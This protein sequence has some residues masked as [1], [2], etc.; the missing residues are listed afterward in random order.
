[1]VLSL[2]QRVDLFIV[3]HGEPEETRGE[4]VAWLK[5]SYPKTPIL[6]LTSVENQQ[7]AGR[8][9]TRRS[10][11]RRRGC[12]W[13]TRRWDEARGEPVQGAATAIAILRLRSG[14]AQNLA[15]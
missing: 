14:D 4:I 11:G 13:W 1:M 6:A 7:L 15:S 8:I 5:D 9:T 2:P 12:R 10:M 3:G